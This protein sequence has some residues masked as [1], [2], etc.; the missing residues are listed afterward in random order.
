MVPVGEDGS[1][2]EGSMA[3]QG[4]SKCLCCGDNFTVDVRNR[5]RQKYCPKKTC[6]AAGKAARQRRW[7]GKPENRDYFRG[8]VHVERVRT[9]RAGHPGYWRAHRRDP[10]IALQDALRPQVVENIEKH[11]DPSVYALQD[12]L[13]A[14]GPVL[15]GL[16]A[17]LSDSTLQD[18]IANTARGLLQLGQDILAR[19]V[20][21]AGQ[22][23]AAS[24][25]A[26]AGAEP[27][28]LDRPTA[29]ARPTP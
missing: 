14:Q 1:S 17:H 19:K 10:G 9:W 2:S 15:I 18:D 5:G 8:P 27:V 11:D 3:N 21:D 13:S 26:A 29:G 25:A 22:K 20:S 6:R 16:I 23:G 24:R 4:Q 28:Q 12:A 7:L